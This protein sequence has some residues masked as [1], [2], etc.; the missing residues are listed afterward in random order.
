MGFMTH[1]HTRFASWSGSGKA[2]LQLHCSSVLLMA[3]V[4]SQVRAVCACQ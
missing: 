2:L 4:H 3:A 1:T